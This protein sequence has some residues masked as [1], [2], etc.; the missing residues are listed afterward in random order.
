MD[1]KQRKALSNL[2]KYDTGNDPFQLPDFQS[3]IPVKQQSQGFNLWDT[4]RGNELTREA[5][6]GKFDYIKPSTTPP[7]DETKKLEI[8]PSLGQKI[9]GVAGGVSSIGQNYISQQ[10]QVANTSE[11]MQNAGQINNNIGGVNYREYNPIT[12]DKELS[13]LD[14][15]GISNT[16]SSTASG[17]AAGA[18]FGP[19]GAVAGGVIGLASGLFGWGSSKSKLRKRIYNAQQLANRL[20]T[21]ARA[22]AMSTVLQNNYNSRYGGLDGGTLYANKGKDKWQKI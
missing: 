13:N 4:V 10:S 8:K 22:G 2:P 1:L 15:S 12:G 19:W 6:P 3:A 18:T 5:V 20:N 16:L 7:E 9:A 21:G 14:K 17:A 11:L